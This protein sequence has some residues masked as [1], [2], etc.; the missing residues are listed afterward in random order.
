MNITTNKAAALIDYKGELE[1]CASVG[2]QEF[3]VNFYF[4]M[5]PFFFVYLLP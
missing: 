3:D 5:R 1:A 2:A 4:I